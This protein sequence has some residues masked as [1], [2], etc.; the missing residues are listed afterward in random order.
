MDAVA[1]AVTA[2]APRARVIGKP[3]AGYFIP[4][5]ET[6]NGELGAAFALHNAS[7]A[8]SAECQ[9]AHAPDGWRCF[10]PAVAAG[11]VRTPLFFLQ[12]RFDLWQLGQG[13]LNI[14]CMRTQPF[15]PPYKPSSCTSEE[16]AEISSYGPTFMSYM[17]ALVNA[18]DSPHGG[19]IN[20]CIVHGS[21]TTPI[22]GA[23]DE[24]AFLEW[25][26]GGRKWWLASCNGSTTAGPCDD[27][28][29]CVPFP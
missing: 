14:P 18:S 8:I 2:I 23:V 7:G 3:I 17:S 15:T 21:T 28:A 6:F 20:A 24:T 4:S 19:F 9:A 13:E 16:D 11:Y 27:A 10:M 29:V 1:A 12:S 22:D 26:A 25:A 5:N